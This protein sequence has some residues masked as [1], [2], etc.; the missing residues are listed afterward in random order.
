MIVFKILK[1]VSF[2]IKLHPVNWLGRKLVK[3]IIVRMY[4]PYVRRNIIKV[5]KLD[6]PFDVVHMYLRE[7][8]RYLPERY[9]MTPEQFVF[10]Y[11]LTYAWVNNSTPTRTMKQFIKDEL[12]RCNEI[13]VAEAN[14]KIK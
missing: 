8:D 7:L 2:N 14:R 6:N 12:R 13:V 9:H 10:Q 4:K 11:H 3:R 5:C 1:G